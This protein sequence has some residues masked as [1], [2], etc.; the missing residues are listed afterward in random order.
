MSDDEDA[1]QAPQKKPWFATN[2]GGIGLHPQTWQGVLV[3]VACV[4][5]LVCVVI[6]LK[7]L[8]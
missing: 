5:V 3:I 2:R 7:S 8:T 4:A 6:L 1:Q